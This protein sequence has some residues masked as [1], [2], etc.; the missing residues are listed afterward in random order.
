MCV[1]AEENKEKTNPLSRLF[2]SGLFVF[3]C[4][5]FGCPIF[6]RRFRGLSAVL[7]VREIYAFDEI[8]IDSCFICKDVP[9]EISFGTSFAPETCRQVVMSE[10]AIIP[11]ISSRCFFFFFSI[12]LFPAFSI[13]LPCFQQ[14]QL[15]TMLV[16]VVAVILV[17]L[18]A[19][20]YPCK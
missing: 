6:D 4:E 19:P 5:S 15:S 12:L 17:A 16:S 9:T 2:S 20:A 1:K 14:T 18:V 11:L 8:M 13:A 3:V 10:H 7:A